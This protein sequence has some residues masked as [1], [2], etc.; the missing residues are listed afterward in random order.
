MFVSEFKEW[1]SWN[2][3]KY[4]ILGKASFGY[5]GLRQRGHLLIFF[6]EDL[7]AYTYRKRNS[8][9]WFLQRIP[10][11]SGSSFILLW[12]TK[13]TGET[14]K[15]TMKNF[16]ST[17]CHNSSEILRESCSCRS[18]SNFHSPCKIHNWVL[19]ESFLT[20]YP[21]ISLVKDCNLDCLNSAVSALTW[22]IAHWAEWKTWPSAKVL[23][24]A[25]WNQK[26]KRSRTGNWG[27]TGFKNIFA[28]FI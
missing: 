23:K 12:T 9:Q 18:S 1:E 10:K 21:P 5:W 22:N 2:V 3:L 27:Y 19:L 4:G 17:F 8:F 14:G 25:D 28:L 15:I 20:H 11:T 24:T 6:E 7:F 13:A 16:T 26:K